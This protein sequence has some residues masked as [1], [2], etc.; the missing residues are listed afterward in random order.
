MIITNGKQ[1]IKK[2]FRSENVCVCF[3]ALMCIYVYVYYVRKRC[4]YGAGQS[5]TNKMTIYIIIGV[6]G[7]ENE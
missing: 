2:S 3:D 7:R 1:Q 5:Q 4:E 6:S